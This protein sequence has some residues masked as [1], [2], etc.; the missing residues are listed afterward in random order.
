MLLH[1]LRAVSGWGHAE[2]LREIEIPTVVVHG[3]QDRLVHVLNGRRLGEMIPNAAYVEL[4]D[5]GHLPPL[6][7]PEALLE[8]IAT[9]AGS[10]RAAPRNGRS[11][12]AA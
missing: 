10:D 7:A 8:A 2:R 12:A 9:V 6:E 5:V 1:Q 4:E 3:A 11:A